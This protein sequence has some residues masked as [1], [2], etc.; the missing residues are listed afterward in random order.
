MIL[1]RSIINDVPFLPKELYRTNYHLETYTK[2]RELS[3]Y[4]WIDD[5]LYSFTG[6]LNDCEKPPLH[7]HC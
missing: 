4:V 7:P 2:S 1:D 5:R 6:F 3:M